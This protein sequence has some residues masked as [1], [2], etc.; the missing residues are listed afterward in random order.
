MLCMEAEVFRALRIAHCIAG[1]A[2]GLTRVTLAES[3]TAAE[4]LSPVPASPLPAAAEERFA[5]RALF[6]GDR[7]KDECP[8]RDGPCVRAFEGAHR[9]AAQHQTR[10]GRR[11]GGLK[12]LSTGLAARAVRA[13]EVDDHVPRPLDHDRE[14]ADVPGYPDPIPFRLRHVLV[15]DADKLGLDGS[16]LRRGAS[17]RDWASDK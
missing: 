17:D 6:V 3:A 4:M 10:A 13:R 16:R 9:N 8:P 7:L 12:I 14:D 5:N 1:E 2:L 15:P 11:D